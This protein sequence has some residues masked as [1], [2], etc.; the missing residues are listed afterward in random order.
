LDRT[1]WSGCPKKTGWGCVKNDFEVL[2]CLEK[3]H[4]IGTNGERKSGGEGLGATG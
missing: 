1:G 3:M 2:A 4:N